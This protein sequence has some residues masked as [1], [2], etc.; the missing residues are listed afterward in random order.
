[1][2]ACQFS[3]AFGACLTFSCHGALVSFGLFHL[4]TTPSLKPQGT[5]THRH[6]RGRTVS[7]EL[8]M[9]GHDFPSDEGRFLHLSFLERLDIFQNLTGRQ[10]DVFSGPFRPYV[11]VHIL[12]C[13]LFR[14]PTVADLADSA[15]L[16]IAMLPRLSGVSDIQASTWQAPKRLARLTRA[17][18]RPW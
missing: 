12:R 8:T 16:R 9:S 17:A 6:T 14:P 11:P 2:S 4:L 1:M 18:S 3:A 15:A 13:S 5:H 7:M 10:T